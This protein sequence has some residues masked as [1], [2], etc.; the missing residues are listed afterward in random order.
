MTSIYALIT[1]DLYWAWLQTIMMMINFQASK[2]GAYLQAWCGS[3]V[4]ELRRKIKG[5]RFFI[6]FV[7]LR[8]LK[9]MITSVVVIF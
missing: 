7:K 9:K 4:C 2:L 6:V 3:F 5:N 1:Y 8:K